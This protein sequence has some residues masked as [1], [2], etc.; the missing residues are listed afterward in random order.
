MTRLFIRDRFIIVLINV[1]YSYDDVLL[2]PQRSKVKSRSDVTLKTNLSKDFYLDL[3]IISANMD[4]VTGVNM[5]IALGKLGG[6]S[7]LPRFN[8]PAEEIEML[9]KVK[10]A[11]VKVGATI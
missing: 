9:L 4:S 1:A 3:P 11:N 10:S 5:A 6:L 7:I 8:S 2:I